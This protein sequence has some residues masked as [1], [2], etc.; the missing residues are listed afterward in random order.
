MKS[1][2]KVKNLKN[3]VVLLRLDLNVAWQGD[4][5]EEAEAFRL[6]AVAPTLRF[7]RKRG[8]KTVILSHLGRPNGRPKLELS[9]A[10]VIRYLAKLLGVK[11]KFVPHLGGAPVKRAVK[12]MRGGEIMALENLR[13]DKR[14]EA[15]E[16]GLASELAAVG[17]LYVNDAFAVCHRSAASL[18]AITKF[19]PSYAGPL[20]EREVKNLSKILIKPKRPL[21]L[22][23]GG[24]KFETKIPIIKKLLPLADKVLLGGGLAT[25]ALA[26]AGYGVGSSTTE[27][28]Y[29]TEAAKL[30]KIKKIVLPIDVIVASK[31]KPQQ[32]RRVVLSKKPAKLVGA[33]EAIYDIGP[34]AIASWA[35]EIKKAATL[36]WNGPVGFFETAPF[37]LGT[38]SLALLVGSR[39][40]GQAFGVVG[41]GETVT[42]LL[43]SQMFQ[44]IDHVS[45]GGGA[46]LEFLAGKRLPGIVALEK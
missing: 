43:Q 10:P 25:T 36:V 5:L 42:A 39:S 15:N 18:S 32:Y 12:K 41:G 24:I 13:F 35:M 30:V 8:A 22:I 23:M 45:T 19:L 14:E 40:S 34:A 21:I 16:A 20:L 31:N 28:E 7:L 17:D 26:A 6:Q 37:G 33:G 27:K 2:T 9:L 3:K 44:Y 1:I 11:I 46:M 38:N 29:F 4:T